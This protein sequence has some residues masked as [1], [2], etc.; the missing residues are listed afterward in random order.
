[1]TAPRTTRCLL[2][3]FTLM[4]ALPVPAVER[5]QLDLQQLLGEAFAAQQVS[6]RLYLDASGKLGLRVRLERF[7]LSP[8]RVFQGLQ[9]ECVHFRLSEAGVD[10][11]EADLKVAESPWGE[12]TAKLKLSIGPRQQEVTIRSL[13]W[14]GGQVGGRVRGRGGRWQA[15]LE[16]AGI[17]LGELYSQLPVR[18]PLEQVS[19]EGIASGH[20]NFRI[21]QAGLQDISG[22]LHVE[23]VQFFEASGLYAAEQLAA[24]LDFTVQRQG[25]DYAS[26]LSVHAQNG[27]AYVDP[28]FLDLQASPL[29]LETDLTLTER[30]LE[31]REL[32]LSWGDRGRLNGAVQVNVEAPLERLQAE[33][34]LSRTPL[35]PLYRH[36]LQPFL[37]GT[38]LD[39]LELAGEVEGELH[40]RQG[41]PV[42]AAL[43]LHRVYADDAEQRFGVYGLEGQLDWSA[44]EER[45][46]RLRINGGHLLG[47]RLGQ[48]DVPLVSYGMRASLP[49]PV[50]VPLMGS[51]ALIRQFA[52]VKGGGWAF[53]GRLQPVSM[54]TITSSLG[55]PVMNGTLAGEVPRVV[56][57]GGEIRVEGVLQVAVFDGDVTIRDLLLQDPLGRVPQLSAEVDFQRLD[58]GLL[59]RTFSFGRIE[60]RLDGRVHEL[61]LL[62]WSP[63]HFD[64]AFYTSPD[65]PGRRRIS[66]R[67]VESLTELGTGV[68]GGVLSKGFL[69]LFEEF[70]YRDIRL[71]AELD[72]GEVLLDGI[73]HPDGGYYLV[74][75]SGLPR[76]DVIGY[77]RRVAWHDLVDRLR[78]ISL[79]GAR[80]R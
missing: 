77:T 40:L 65:D 8:D 17:R 71:T 75:G 15:E 35:A 68:P 63:V 12:L 28:V 42:K 11:P 60:G 18:L 43:K 69:G 2:L 36:W 32:S 79:E 76:I 55:W 22:Q 47:M 70:R 3:L 30:R 59:T 66:Q 45:S 56:Y 25:Q 67:A 57:E 72:D 41:R 78:S 10:C 20:L 44:E 31:A 33:L 62:D 5:L 38:A 34:S 9:L 58:L 27:Q 39:S 49:Q 24:V 48:L 51:E 19:L 16:L 37:I 52:W 23:Q 14:A 54:A 80:I 21:G 61:R 13:Q 1:M 73:A 4:L 64:A 50:R 6:A 53:S 26:R 46:S 74:R 29:Q 7:E